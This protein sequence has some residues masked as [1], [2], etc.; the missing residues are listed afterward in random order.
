MTLSSTEEREV[1]KE[2]LGADNFEFSELV[3]EGALEDGESRTDWFEGACKKDIA[4]DVVLISGH[5]AGTFFGSNPR[6][7]PISTMQTHACDNSC[8]GILSNA[9][10]VFLMGCNTLAGNDSDERT[11]EEYIQVLID[12][13]F[14]QLQAERIAEYRYGGFGTTFKSRMKR[15]FKG[16]K[17]LYGFSSVGPSG[18]RSQPVLQEYFEEIGDYTE[19]LDQIELSEIFKENSTLKDAYKYS[20]FNQCLASQDNSEI[21]DQKSIEHLIWGESMDCSLATKKLSREEKLK[22]LYDVLKDGSITN[23]LLLVEEFVSHLDLKELN[24]NEEKILSDISSLDHIKKEVSGLIDQIQT[25]VL[26]SQVLNVARVFKWLTDEKYKLEMNKVMYELLKNGVDQN[27]IDIIVSYF[28]GKG[29]DMRFS[30]IPSEVYETENGII[31]LAYLKVED[32]KVIKRIEDVILKKYKVDGIKGFDKY[33]QYLT[34]Y[35]KTLGLSETFMEVVLN[36]IQKEHHPDHL[37]YLSEFISNE[38][39]KNKNEII[40]SLVK[41]AKSGDLFKG[42][43]PRYLTLSNIISGLQLNENNRIDIE[44]ELISYLSISSDTVW[45]YGV[46]KKFEEIGLKSKEAL[47]GLLAE[48]GNCF[49]GKSAIGADECQPSLARIIET[50]DIK[51][52]SPEVHER[53]KKILGNKIGLNISPNTKRSLFR[54]YANSFHHNREYTRDILAILCQEGIN[55]KNETYNSYI[56]SYFEYEGLALTNLENSPILELLLDTIGDKKDCSD[57]FNKYFEFLIDRHKQNFLP[58]NDFEKEKKIMDYLIYNER[59]P[60]LLWQGIREKGKF[61][62]ESI[63]Y[64]MRRVTEQF[65]KLSKEDDDIAFKKLQKMSIFNADMLD[66][67]KLKKEYFTYLSEVHSTIQGMITHKH[68]FERKLSYHVEDLVQSESNSK[69]S[70]FLIDNYSDFSSY[71]KNIS[72]QVLAKGTFDSEKEQEAI[73][74]HIKKLPKNALA[75]YRTLLYTMKGKTKKLS[76]LRERLYFKSN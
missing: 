72:N 40:K 59:L 9:T 28:L 18:K 30:D 67:F 17:N 20:S 14:T 8:S 76:K 69:F 47:N 70:S 46:R 60:G 6:H 56:S 5:F 31:A 49:T 7:L 75:H 25:P 38:D 22:S 48:V 36:E 55:K 53:V 33:A 57:A 45:N 3:P 27:E 52:F 37:Y 26:R 39:F 32:Q 58:L 24:K 11:R 4:C 65:I 50:V 54:I 23:R 13:G 41:K 35:N 16:S 66:N 71:Q 62:E 42:L 15:V 34:W 43:N 64:Y 1:F 12:D 74:K 29:K 2:F 44:K 73:L 19:H 68:R 61:S 51:L 10:E 63:I 21:L